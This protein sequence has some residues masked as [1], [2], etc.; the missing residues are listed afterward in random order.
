MKTDTRRLNSDYSQD[1]SLQMFANGTGLTAVS[2]G[3]RL[4]PENPYPAAINDC[5]DVGEYLVGNPSEYGTVRFLGGESAGAYLALLTSFH[6]LRTRPSHKISGLVLRY[7]E[8][9]LAVGL[10]AIVA[11]SSTK[12]LMIDRN[13]MERFNRA[14]LPR[15]SLEERRNPSLSPL[16]EDLTALAAALFVCGTADPLLDDT[17]LMGMK[18]S[19][20]GGESIVKVYPGAAHGF[21]VIP[22]LPVAEEANAVSVQ[23]MREKLDV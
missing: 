22:G 11:S 2:V 12:A 5:I 1:R 19:I 20:A 23:F 21:T 16:Y 8:Y 6:L 17:L 15:P 14:Y 7:G 4:A 9:D 18:W 10:P 13:A 3:Y